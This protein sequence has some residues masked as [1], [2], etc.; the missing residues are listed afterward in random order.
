VTGW[1]VGVLLLLVILLHDFVL[2]HQTIRIKSLETSF[3][4]YLYC[5][6]RDTRR[7]ILANVPLL[8]LNILVSNTPQIRV[9][10]PPK[11]PPVD[12]DWWKSKDWV[13][14]WVN[15]TL[16]LVGTAQAI[17]MSKSLK[18]AQAAAKAATAIELPRIRVKQPI[19][20]S[21]DRPLGSASLA[22]AVENS[23]NLTRHSTVKQIIVQN[24]GRT[25]ADPIAMKIGWLVS[26]DL[27]ISP[28][29][30]YFANFPHGGTLRSE[31]EL[32]TTVN[33]DIRL[34]DQEIEYT[35]SSSASFWLYIE[36]SYRDCIGDEHEAS[37]CCRRRAGGD[38]QQHLF[39]AHHVPAAYRRQT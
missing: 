1:P 16:V 23:G 28:Q 22:N 2:P 18:A 17:F 6:K 11:P 30:K 39:F 26:K 12:P 33:L 24:H 21:I 25:D 38:G 36:V 8:D 20:L 34:T 9:S 35:K 37:F 15:I 4:P 7:Q 5:N 32:T 29:Y 19:L 10:Q 13:P 14:V 31:K 27:P 3:G